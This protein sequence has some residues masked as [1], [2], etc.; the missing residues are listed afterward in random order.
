V[1]LPV[2]AATAIAATNPATHPAILR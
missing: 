1:T 2:S